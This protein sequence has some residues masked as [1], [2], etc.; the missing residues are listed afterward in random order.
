MVVSGIMG[1]L[2]DKS[3]KRK[4][5]GDIQKA[6]LTSIKLAGLLSVA[7]LAPN[8]VRVLKSF[9]LIPGR[10]QKEIILRSRDR[11]VDVGLLKYE[12]S[13]LKLTDKGEVYLRNL[14]M[15]DWKINKPHKWDSK[16]RMLIFDI[17]EYRRSLR[18]KVRLTL[19][20]IGFIRLQD[21][22]WIYPYDCEDLVNLFKADFKIGRDL[23]YLIVDFIEN[24]RDYRK[25]FNLPL[26]K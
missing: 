25:L 14:E 7:V 24:D 10:R 22:V 20:K 5:R 19:L 9:G 6:V 23:L 18:E 3:K 8:A 13:F 16:W 4:R 11:L 2:E 12:D 26:E 17:P 1:I 15:K 21:S